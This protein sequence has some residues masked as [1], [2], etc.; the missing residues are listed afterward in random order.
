[1]CHAA[2]ALCTDYPTVTSYFIGMPASEDL[3][4]CVDTLHPSQQS[5]SHVG[6]ISCFPGVNQYISKQRIKC[7]AQG[8]NTVP[9]ENLKPANLRSQELTLYH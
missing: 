2:M 9:P 8:H 7:L 5:F 6:T 4:V 3:F 1:M